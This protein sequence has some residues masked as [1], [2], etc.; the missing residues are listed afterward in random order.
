[1]EATLEANPGTLDSDWLFVARELGWDRISLGAQSLDDELLSRLGRIHSSV[2]VLEALEEA[3][4][5]GFQRISVDLMVGIPGQRLP[6]VLEDAERLVET[7]AEHLSVYMLDL[8]KNCPLKAQ[9]DAGRL[10]LPSED[11]VADVYE[12]LQSGLPGVGLQPYEISNYAVPGQES[13]HNS[14]YWERRP[15]LGIGPSAAS[16][17]GH[18]RWTEGGVISAWSEGRA[19]TEVQ[20]LSPQEELAEIPLLALRT[21]RGVDW[22]ALRTL[23]AQ[24]DLLPIVEDWERQM[25][26]FLRAGLLLREGDQLHFSNRGMLLSNSV[27]QMFV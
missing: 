2:Q 26:P 19:E 3:A 5:A 23:A 14:R 17:L 21:H 27:F 6:R 18:W 25:E 10:Q 16:Q 15:Y 22:R 8:D 11:E 9:V 24:L 1:V 4:C 13:I 12:A 20:E 7:G